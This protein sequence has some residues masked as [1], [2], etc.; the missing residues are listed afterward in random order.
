MG[1][2]SMKR[3][4]LSILLTLAM[5]LTLL[6]VSAM[7]EGENYDCKGGPDC[8]HKVAKIND[9][10]RYDDVVAHF[11]TLEEAIRIGYM[12]PTPLTIKLLGDLT[13]DV[14]VPAGKDIYLDL[15]GHKL[16]NASGHTITVENGGEL[17]IS[18][19]VGTGVVD[20]TSHGKA[21][22]YN[23]GEV[24]LN[25]G[26]FERSAEKGTPDSANGNSWYTVKNF[27]TMEII[28]GVTIKN[29]GSFSSAIA[30]GW[31]DVATAGKGSEPAHSADA[32]LTING[33]NIS[34]GKITV[35]NDDCGK[36]TINSGTFTQSESNLYCVYNANVAE[37]TGGTI[38]GNVGNIKSH[39]ENNKGEFTITGGTFNTDVSAYVADGYILNNGT[40]EKLGETN[41]VA[42][43]GENYYGTFIDALR[44]ATAEDTVTLLKDAELDTRISI[45]KKITLDLAG[46][47]IKN[48]STVKAESGL[49]V[50]DNEGDFTINDSS[51]EK[52]G[53]IN[54]AAHGDNLWAAVLIW[55]DAGHTAKLTVN[56]G[57]LK[58]YSYPITGNGT[59][60]EE[61]CTTITINGGKLES[62]NGLAIYHPQNGKLTVNGGELIGQETAIE[63]RAGVL[64]I[65]DGTFTATNKPTATQPN[66]SGTTTDGAAIAVCQ[67]TTK[68]RTE[69][70][71]NGGTFNGF[72][73][74]YEHNAQNNSTE[75]LA[76]VKLNITGG[77]FKTING[78]TVAVY[79][80]DKTGFITGGLFSS[81]SAEKYIAENHYVDAS[82]NGDY[83]YTVKEGTKTDAPI[84]VKDATDVTVPDGAG[85]TDA[86]KDAIKAKS[87][88]DGVAEAIADNKAALIPADVDTTDAKKV[89]IEVTVKVNVTGADMTSENKTL[90]YDVSPVATVTVTKADGTTVTKNDVKVPNSMLNRQPITVKLPLPTV[91]GQLFT[92]KQILHKFTGGGYEYFINKDEGSKRGAGSF[93]IEDGCA[94]FTIYGFSTFE[95]SGTVTYVEPSSGGGSS[96]SSR[97]YDVSAPSVKH[98][99]VTVSPKTASKGDTVTITVKPD[100]GYEL[101]TLTVKDASGS[102]IKVKDKGDG[103]FTF[104]M[105]ASKVTVS[106]EFAEIEMLD[107]ADVSTDAYYYEAVK[108]AAKKGITGGT[109]D[110]NFNPNG[111][112]TRAHIVTFLWRAAGSPEPK[113]TVSFADV[114]ADSYYAKAVAWAVENGITLGT[115]DG[116]FSPN[117]TCTRAQ[118]VTFLYRA[119]GTASTTVNGFTDVAADAFYADAVAWAVE[120]GVTNGTSAS[121][122][123]PNNGCTRAQI[124]TFL[125]RTMK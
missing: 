62:V 6:P 57:T 7:A 94:V 75:D 22:I 88:V 102:K 98:G 118:S 14:V 12:P 85:L 44:A 89:E 26:T 97:R 41:A 15:N 82:N 84:I 30:N 64:T 79:S 37:I 53:M 78:G 1:G 10:P 38:N 43:V 65:N 76:K 91:G 96:S 115:G 72:S 21:A 123:S 122:F 109:G 29:E 47:T 55:P 104:T 24:T 28:S 18:D 32:V 99:D 93:K 56:G 40:V 49:F 35:K 105:P 3:K 68:L 51:A 110:G 9:D 112:C 77:N 8:H 125:Y 27:G 52:T 120:S 13:E 33:G 121:T 46:H 36:L 86:D 2:Y 80:A 60:T 117:A 95:L 113:S 45:K 39:T 71:I 90:T 61:D 107:F 4:F 50:V 70:T 34:G 103:K 42:K 106:A 66:G 23:E 31:Y 63:M 81:E 16:T 101:D 108:W 100:S 92:P 58:G 116:T 74:F 124:V 69:V 19:S 25:G 11:D 59:C 5:A 119:Q 17:N 20:N 87:N 73:A 114:P 67:H 48:G 83:P 54:A 111:S